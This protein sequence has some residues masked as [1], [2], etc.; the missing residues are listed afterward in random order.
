MKVPLYVKTFSCGV[1]ACRK[2][3]YEE[4]HA[5]YGDFEG[6]DTLVSSYEGP[7]SRG[8]IPSSKTVDY[9][10]ENVPAGVRTEHECQPRLEQ[11]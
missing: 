5:T 3:D 7:W 6:R 1:D 2:C 10:D 11:Q 9:T 8:R 4:G